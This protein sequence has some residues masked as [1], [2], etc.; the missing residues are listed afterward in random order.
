MSLR[1][2]SYNWGQGREAR[3]A[4]ERIDRTHAPRRWSAAQIA[5]R[6]DALAAY[7]RRLSGMA[8][9]FIKAQRDKGLWNALEHDDWAG[10]GGVTGQ[11]Y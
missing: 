7:P 5:E 9:G 1:Q 2:S 11:H 6:L 4:I 3:I 10:R 8:L